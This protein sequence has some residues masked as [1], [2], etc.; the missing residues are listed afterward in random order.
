MH[1]FDIL[2][3]SPNLYLFQKESNKTNFGGFLFLVYLVI[4][5]IV[6]IYYIIDYG[7]NPPYIIQ[8]FNHFNYKK[9]EEIEERNMQNKYNPFINYKIQVN[10]TK[11]RIKYDITNYF[12][13]YDYNRSRFI[14]SNK[15]FYDR[16]DTFD[17]GLYFVC[18]DSNCSNY[19]DLI[20]NLSQSDVNT[21][22][23][24]FSYEGFV[25]DHQNPEGPIRREGRI[26]IN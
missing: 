19:F 10:Y 22:D 2:S 16:I 15:T 5:I 11:N 24:I 4:V 9:K 17:Y 18:D 12:I 13:L 26:Y 3:P 23:V 21:F 8:S 6:L 20:K 1:P 25:L 14:D 7:K